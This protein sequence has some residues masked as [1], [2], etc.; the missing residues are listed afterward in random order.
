MDWSGEHHS[1]HFIITRE[2][3]KDKHRIGHTVWS[4][5]YWHTLQVRM[6]GRK[7]AE[8]ITSLTDNILSIMQKFCH[9]LKHYQT[10]CCCDGLRLAS[11]AG[12]SWIITG[13]QSRAT[14]LSKSLVSTKLQSFLLKTGLGH[15]QSLRFFLLAEES[16]VLVWVLLTIR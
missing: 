7:E 9:R 13:T 10:A 1:Q 16:L 11:R 8:I 14:K 4:T 12:A 15:S 3:K 2:S 6:L 5:G